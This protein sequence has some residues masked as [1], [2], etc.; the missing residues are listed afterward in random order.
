MEN[1]KI[2]NPNATHKTKN[3]E[4]YMSQCG[5]EDDSQAILDE[6]NSR[7]EELERR[8]KEALEENSHLKLQLKKQKSDP[9]PGVNDSQSCKNQLRESIQQ[10]YEPTS[11]PL[12]PRTN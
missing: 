9:Y 12:K 10:K 7:N 4:K 2:S 6:I 1:L 3:H 8:L 11:Q 5:D